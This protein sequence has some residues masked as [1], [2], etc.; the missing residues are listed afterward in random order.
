M[1]GQAWAPFVRVAGCCCRGRAVT[2]GEVKR[3][4][5]GRAPTWRRGRSL[6]FR[7]LVDDAGSCP[8]GQD[9]GMAADLR[10][11]DALLPFGSL[12]GSPGRQR[13][14]LRFRPWPWERARSG[15]AVA[16]RGTSRRTL[17]PDSACPGVPR[18]G[19]TSRDHLRWGVGKAACSSRTRRRSSSMM[20]RATCSPLLRWSGADVSLVSVA[21]AP[22]V[23]LWQ[24][25][26]GVNSRDGHAPHNP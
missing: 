11:D 20:G 2:P 5:L 3:P 22:G 10:C 13:L 18:I 21:H 1:A 4:F 24:C 25:A 14:L 15:A 17:D 23:W 19:R 12:P 26:T 9:G 7:W 16:N 8:W 6:T